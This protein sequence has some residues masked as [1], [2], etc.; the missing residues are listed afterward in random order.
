MKA[1]YSSPEPHRQ[2]IGGNGQ[3]DFLAAYRE[4]HAVSKE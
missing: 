1:V 4:G 3:S 2:I